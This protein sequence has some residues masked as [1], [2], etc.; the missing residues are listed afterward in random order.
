MLS[1]FC[2]TLIRSG[3]TDKEWQL[4]LGSLTAYLVFGLAGDACLDNS[5]R[6]A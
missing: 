4:I 5:V 6:A 2:R 1:I 3:L